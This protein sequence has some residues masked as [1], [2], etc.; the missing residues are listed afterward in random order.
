MCYG[1]N[2]AHP[3]PMKVDY[4]DRDEGPPERATLLRCIF[5]NPFRSV[6]FDPRW[7]TSDTVALAQAIYDHRA[8]ERLPILGD[9]LMD[10]GCEDE[11]IIGHCRSEGPHVRGC[12][13]VDLVLNK[14]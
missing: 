7:R 1:V 4:I 6:T 13:V 3:S 12:W 11:Q 8:F 2:A 9:A 5:A 14:Q 10:A